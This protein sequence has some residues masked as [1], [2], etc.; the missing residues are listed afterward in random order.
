MVQDGNINKYGT[1]KKKQAYSAIT[2][3]LAE[4]IF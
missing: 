2:S 4:L 1:K 3:L